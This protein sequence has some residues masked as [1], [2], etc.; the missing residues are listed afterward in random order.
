M[1]AL[2]GTT[3]DRPEVVTRVRVLIVDD[4]AVVRRGIRAY[5]EVLDD[6]EVAAEAKQRSKKDAM[7]ALKQSLAD[8][9]T[10]EAKGRREVEGEH[11][12]QTAALR[13]ERTKDAA[14]VARLVKAAQLVGQQFPR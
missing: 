9:K 14:R 6:L 3:A 7:K 12:R 10:E 13:E 5:L 1:N 8:V 11:A 4:H 2:D